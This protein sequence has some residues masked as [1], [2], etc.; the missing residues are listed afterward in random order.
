MATKRPLSPEEVA[1]MLSGTWQAPVASES[2]TERSGPWVP[3]YD[4][5][6]NCKVMQPCLL[7][8]RGD[9]DWSPELPLD[10]PLR[11]EIQYLRQ[12]TGERTIL[13]CPTC[14]DDLRS[15][16]AARVAASTPPQLFAE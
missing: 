3:R 14:L 1:D 2:T 6:A 11:L 5:C 4:R 10:D 12:E 16:G 15:T 9:S 8:F 7:T 13:L